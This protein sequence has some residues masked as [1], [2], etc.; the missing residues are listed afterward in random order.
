[1][2]YALYAVTALYAVLSAVAAAV[3]MKSV[4]NKGTSLIMIGGALVL[5]AAIIIHI[6]KTPYGWIAAAI[7]GLLICA[8]ALINGKKSGS[9]HIQHH[10]IRFTVTILLIIGYIFL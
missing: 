6:L 9:F 5:T 7:G 1:M 2:K 10:I 3:Q 4:K 8:A